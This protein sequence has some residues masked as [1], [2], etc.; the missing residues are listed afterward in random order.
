MTIGPK[1]ELVYYK[2]V[3]G[4]DALSS[5]IETWS[6]KRKVTGVLQ[7]LTGNERLANDKVTV[8][9][10]HRFYIEPPLEMSVSETEKLV[11][12]EVVDEGDR[13]FKITHIHN[14]M[15]QG[16]HYEVDLLEET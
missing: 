8:I 5:R 16:R 15:E 9:R 1:K 6:R 10:T 2:L 12:P 3:V 11:L 7:V 4:K 13:T 14:P